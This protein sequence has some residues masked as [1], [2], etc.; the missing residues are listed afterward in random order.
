MTLLQFEQRGEDRSNPSR[1]GCNSSALGRVMTNWLGW[2][3]TLQIVDSRPYRFTNVQKRGSLNCALLSRWQLSSVNPDGLLHAQDENQARGREPEYDARLASKAA[4]ASKPTE[5]RR[6]LSLPRMLRLP[7]FWIR[8]WN[9]CVA[10]V[11]LTSVVVRPP[12]RSLS[13]TLFCRSFGP[14]RF[15]AA[16]TSS[17]GARLIPTPPMGDMA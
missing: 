1:Y 17:C 12:Q 5:P 4:G 9:R 7:L 2:A 15:A 3:L 16:T 13:V 8:I 14:S 6:V 11:R 10:R